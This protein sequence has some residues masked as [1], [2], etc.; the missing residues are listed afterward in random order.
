MRIMLEKRAS[1]EQKKRRKVGG[2]FRLEQYP[3]EQWYLFLVLLLITSLTCMM[4]SITIC[5]VQ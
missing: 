3:E 5:S 1:F 4:E 2:E